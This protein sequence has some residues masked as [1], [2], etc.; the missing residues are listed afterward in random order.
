MWRRK[1][2]STEHTDQ[3]TA[4]IEQVIAEWDAD[5]RSRRTRRAARV[6]HDSF[7]AAHHGMIDPQAA[8]RIHGAPSSP[9]G[10][11]LD[12]VLGS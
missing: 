11:I 9:G 5:R 4:P 3:V 8:A 1:R 2:Y 10:E 6:G 7:I 12:R